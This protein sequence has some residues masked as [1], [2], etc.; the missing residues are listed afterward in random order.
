[1]ADI[2][3]NCGCRANASFQNKPCC[4]VHLCQEVVKEQPKLE[5]RMAKCA[6][7]E[8]AIVPS[9]LG[10]AFF[11]YKGPGSPY[12]SNVCKHCRMYEI[13]HENGGTK[14]R[15]FE[16]IGPAECDTYY[17]GCRGWD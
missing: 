2:L 10:L 8:H 3:M 13:A 14:C 6:Y 12:A 11:E 16:P 9:S 4:A 1:M 5:E 17:C 15:N 7:G